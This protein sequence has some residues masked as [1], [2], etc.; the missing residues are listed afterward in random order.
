MDAPVACE[1]VVES[2]VDIFGLGVD[3]C[4]KGGGVCVCLE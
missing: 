1:W 3:V 2:E 4:D